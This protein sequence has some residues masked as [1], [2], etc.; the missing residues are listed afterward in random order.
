MRVRKICQEAIILAG[1]LGT[2][3]RS[4]IVGM[5]KA[6][7]PINDL[8][9]LHYSLKYLSLNNIRHVILSVGYLSEQIES[10]FGNDYEGI[11]ITYSK[12]QRPLGTGGATLLALKFLT[13]QEPFFVINGD[14]FHNINLMEMIK[15][16]HSNF[17]DVTVSTA[18]AK[19]SLRYGKVSFDKNWQITNYNDAKADKGDYMNSGIYLFSPKLKKSHVRKETICLDN[20]IVRELLLQNSRLFGYFSN[21]YFIDIGIPTD[22]ETAQLTVP[23]LLG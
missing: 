9:F 11:K 16:H 20:D 3:L 13:S 7:A 21:N 23:D 8:P 14:S 5:P 17:A 6:L 2:R 4:K 1:G 10:Y 15:N 18:L 12:E 22:Y 19:E